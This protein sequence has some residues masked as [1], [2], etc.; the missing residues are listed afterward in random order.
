MLR[1]NLSLLI[2]VSGLETILNLSKSP[3]SWIGLIMLKIFLV[4]VIGLGYSQSNSL[5]WLHSNIK[6]MDVEECTSTDSMSHRFLRHSVVLTNGMEKPALGRGNRIFLLWGIE[7]SL[8]GRWDYPVRLD[9]VRL[10]LIYSE[11]VQWGTQKTS[12]LKG[13]K[14]YLLPCRF[15]LQLVFNRS[16]G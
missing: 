3:N 8:I 9:L 1:E 11:G 12:V 7:W 6:G 14:S 15:T 16:V 13:C 2:S 10:D 5:K 4:L